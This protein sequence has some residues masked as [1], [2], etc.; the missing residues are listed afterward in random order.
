MTSRR[1]LL[2]AGCS[3]A[4]GTWIGAAQAKPAALAAAAFTP[5][6]KS[7]VEAVHY[8][9]GFRGYRATGFRFYGPRRFY[10]GAAFYGPRFYRRAYWAPRRYYRAAFWAPRRYYRARYWRPRAAYW[11]PSY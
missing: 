4:L 6:A 9:R 2:L 1:L 5:E 11:G 10:R 3:L 8:R 7:P